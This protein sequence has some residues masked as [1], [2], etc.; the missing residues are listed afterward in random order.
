MKRACG[1]RRTN[2]F[3]E[4][5]EAI[6]DAA[7]RAMFVVDGRIDP[8]PSATYDDVGTT[9]SYNDVIAT[10][11]FKAQFR[12]ELNAANFDVWSKGRNWA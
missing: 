6:A 11:R 8:T 4:N 2:M 12:K 3:F 10:R 5:F 1:P 7:M 9:Y